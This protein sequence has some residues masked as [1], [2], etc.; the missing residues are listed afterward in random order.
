MDPRPDASRIKARL[1]VVPQQDNL[2]TEI[3]VRENLL[4]YARYFDIPRGVARRRADEL[5]DFVELR[6]RADA[7]VESLSGGMKRRLT[8][9]RAL[10]N[11]PDVILLDEPTTGLDPQ[12]RHVVWERLYQLKRRGAT[13]LLTTH[14]MDEAERLCDRLVVMDKARIVAEGSPRELIEKYSTREVLE[15]RFPEDVRAAAR[16]PPRR[17]RRAGRDAARSRPDLHDRRRARASS[18]CTRAAFRS[19]A[20]SSVVRRSRMCSSASPGERP[21]RMIG[22]LRMVQRNA[23]VYR[24]VWRGSVFS[25]FLQPTL[26]LIAMGLGL[27]GMIDPARRAARRRELS[28]V[29]CAR[30]CSQQRPCRSRRSSRPTRCSAR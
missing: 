9:A 24:H 6:D 20:P 26:F 11:E 18:R 17:N 27:G 10:V 8:I 16:R 29:S 14:Y 19:R 2:D 5:L 4:M 28:G 30:A 15:L 7:Q 13:L 1:G 23:L 12:A 25:S 22:A 3:T 21:R